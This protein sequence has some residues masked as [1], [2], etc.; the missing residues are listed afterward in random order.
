M[1]DGFPVLFTRPL[2]G[3]AIATMIGE[4]RLVGVPLGGG[5]VGG[6]LLAAFARSRE[7]VRASVVRRAAELRR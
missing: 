1:S 7:Q 6:V 4:G 2:P 5:I 3:L